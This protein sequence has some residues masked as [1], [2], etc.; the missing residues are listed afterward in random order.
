M[1][2]AA[3]KL[4][5]L[6]LGRKGMTELGSVLL[7]SRDITLP[8]KVYIVRAMVSLVVMNGWISLWIPERECHLH[9][10]FDV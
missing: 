5:R 7:Q 2:T 1:L 8:T 3:M 4:R 6:L 10:K 9:T